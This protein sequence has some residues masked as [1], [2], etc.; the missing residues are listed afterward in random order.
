M[1]KKLVIM[2]KNVKKFKCGILNKFA[3]IEYLHKIIVLQ[4]TLKII[5][6][7]FTTKSLE[8]NINNA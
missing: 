5:N 7:F 2:I 6:N 3:N 4:K 8:F 1:V